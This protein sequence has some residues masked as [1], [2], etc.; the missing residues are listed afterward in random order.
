[1]AGLEIKMNCVKTID[2]GMTL[3]WRAILTLDMLQDC[4]TGHKSWCMCVC[5]YVNSRRW[6]FLILFEPY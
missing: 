4:I 2:Q 5:V 3:Y 1:M 6:R